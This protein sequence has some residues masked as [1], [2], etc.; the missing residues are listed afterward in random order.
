[1]DMNFCKPCVS[2]ID[3][4]CTDCDASKTHCK[5]CNKAICRDHVCADTACAPCF[6]KEVAEQSMRKQIARRM[7]VW[8]EP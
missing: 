3:D 8:V 2:K 4:P 6:R 7:R 1:M 5:K